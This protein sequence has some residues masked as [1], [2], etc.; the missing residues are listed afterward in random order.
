MKKNILLIVILVTIGT[1]VTAQNIKYDGGKD[2]IELDNVDTIKIKYKW[3]DSYHSSIL[4]DM[5]IEY[6]KPSDFNETDLYNSF[7]KYRVLRYKLSTGTYALCSND[8]EFIALLS[9]YPIYTK[10]TQ[11]K[12]EEVF[13]GSFDWIGVQHFYQMK[14][15]LKSFY[16]K[17]M[18]QHWREKIT[19]YPKEEAIH[20]FN[21]DNAYRFSIALSPEDY[22]EK[23]FKYVDLLFLQKK[24]RG[25]V[26]FCCFYTDKAKK[27]LNKYW[28]K[29][30]KVFYYSD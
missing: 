9:I 14:G 3:I 29:I 28:S 4:E 20:K 16:G 12:M 5:Q 17:E 30:E 7:K 11:R 1:I 6:K 26:Y 25:Y 8:K 21:A 10:E 2:L 19:T 18:E 13:P 15:I 27:E 22:Y 23:K 24:G